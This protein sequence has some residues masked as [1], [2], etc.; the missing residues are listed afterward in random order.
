MVSGDPIKVLIWKS[1]HKTN[2]EW[3]HIGDI[4]NTNKKGIRM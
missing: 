2:L 1:N 4:Y 3:Q